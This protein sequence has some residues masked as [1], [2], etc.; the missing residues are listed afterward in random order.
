MRAPTDSTTLIG[1]NSATT[2]AANDQSALTT[3]PTISLTTQ[4]LSS[5]H[6]HGLARGVS[7][8]AH[9]VPELVVAHPAQPVVHSSSSSLSSH[10]HD[11]SQFHVAMISPATISRMAHGDALARI[12]QLVS[13]TKAAKTKFGSRGV[14]LTDDKAL[15]AALK[16]HCK[17]NMMNFQEQQEIRRLQFESHGRAQ[18]KAQEE[19]HYQETKQAAEQVKDWFSKLQTARDESYAK[20]L[21]RFVW[22]VLGRVI[23][24]LAF[25]AHSMQQAGVAGVVVRAHDM[26]MDQCQDHAVT[27]IIRDIW[28]SFLSTSGAAV[29]AAEVTVKQSSWMCSVRWGLGGPTNFFY[30]KAASAASAMTPAWMTSVASALIHVAGHVTKETSAML[31][32]APCYGGFVAFG[33]G[34]MLMMTLTLCIVLPHEAAIALMVAVAVIVSGVSWQYVGV[35]AALC[36]VLAGFVCYTC[37]KLIRQSKQSTP[38]ERELTQ[39]LVDLE[40]TV[41]VGNLLPLLGVITFSVLEAFTMMLG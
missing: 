11:S 39:A 36:L 4:S 41:T 21:W 17:T 37:R 18:R 8:D 27:A 20:L 25:Q 3:P 24:G 23:I 40:D 1:S 12:D 26:V 29:A 15:E 28:S 33:A 9:E 35:A 30:D 13:L 6:D 16:V 32:L 31:P 34:A 19:R 38:T 22:T 7:L 5:S 10:S 14:E 2:F